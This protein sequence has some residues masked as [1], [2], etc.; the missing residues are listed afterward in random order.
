MISF[1]YPRCYTTGNMLAVP[2]TCA[3][4]KGLAYARLHSEG[5]KLPITGWNGQVPT[6]TDPGRSDGA[7]EFGEIT[8]YGETPDSESLLVKLGN[9]IRGFL[10][11]GNKGLDVARL[12]GVV[13]AV[14]IGG[15][16]LLWYVPRKKR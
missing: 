2:Y 12:W 15:G 13:A 8:I 16:L 14:G 1:G 11:L 10:N 4:N 9:G 6:T 7:Y 3:P 5:Q